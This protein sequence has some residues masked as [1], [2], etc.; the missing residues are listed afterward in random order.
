M[1]HK[2]RCNYTSGH[3]GRARLRRRIWVPLLLGTFLASCDPGG[4][5]GVSTTEP[6][7][8]TTE[9]GEPTTEPGEPTTEPGKPTTEPGEPTTE[10]GEPMTETKAW[11]VSTFA[12][13]G[14]AGTDGIG[15]AAGFGTP[16]GIVQIGDTFYVTDQANHSIRTVHAATAEVKTIVPANTEGGYKD[17]A[18]ASARFNMP[19]GA[20]AGA[21]G[22][23]Y[24]ADFQNHLI[25]AVDLKSPD[26]TVTTIAGD[27]AAGSR[28][29]KG[30]EAQFNGPSDLAV[31]GNTLYV[32]DFSN[33]RIRAID[34]ADSEKTVTTIAGSG[35]QG[36]ADGAGTTA[37]FNGPSGL[38]VSGDTLYVVEYGNNLIRAVNLADSDNTVTTIAGDRTAK[39][40]DGTG[41]AAQLN[42]PA[43]LVAIGN[44]LYFT[45]K[46][47]HRIRTM[48]IT[49]KRVLTIA[50]SGTKGDLNGI[51]TA[52]QFSLP[53][54]IA[55]SGSTL[56]VTSG[57]QIR[58]L[59]YR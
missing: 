32:A 30:T 51:G 22:T 52:A 10:P 31:I 55:G 49:T 41:T 27:R 15:S 21:D 54:H 16:H 57:N 4:A 44:T 7:E 20:A 3:P 37:Q 43:A 59:E 1:I 47:S 8:P 9:P 25:R 18:A 13:G 6:G 23:L 34:L 39:S 45:E 36:N 28:N 14:A 50:G 35:T 33:H 24:V 11:H 2:D 26:K 48:D 19:R 53:L 5:G 12:G 58:K 17:D 42:G 46:E 56:Y 29:G 38:A 40:T